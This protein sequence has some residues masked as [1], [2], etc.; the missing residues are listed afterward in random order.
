MKEIR[1]RLNE[2]QTVGTGVLDSPFPREWYTRSEGS[3]AG[4]DFLCGKK[5]GKETILWGSAP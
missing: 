4:S 5:V 2:E 1:E 3:L